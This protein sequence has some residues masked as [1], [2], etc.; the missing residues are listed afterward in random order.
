MTNAAS[1]KRREDRVGISRV[2]S[3]T[4]GGGAALFLATAFALGILGTVS[5]AVVKGFLLESD[6]LLRGLALALPAILISY[7]VLYFVTSGM[8]SV[9]AE[10]SVRVSNAIRQRRSRIGYWGRGD[11]AF[12]LAWLSVVGP[13][14]ALTAYVLANVLGLDSATDIDAIGYTVLLCVTVLIHACQ[15]ALVPTPTVSKPA[16]R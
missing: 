10:S 9:I 7:L 4:T 5:G 16:G 15:R 11:Y 14:V 13:I 12:L 8:I 2:L 1:T 3:W 6:G